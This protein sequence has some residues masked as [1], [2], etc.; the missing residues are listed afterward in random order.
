MV[1]SATGVSGEVVLIGIDATGAL[2][3]TFGS[4][5]IAVDTQTNGLRVNAIAVGQGGS[6]LGFG[7]VP[8]RRSSPPP[9]SS[10]AS[11]R[12]ARAT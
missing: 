11:M 10:S 9:Q 6:I 1:F 5:G 8:G 4:G 7:T 3:A 12:T 2:D